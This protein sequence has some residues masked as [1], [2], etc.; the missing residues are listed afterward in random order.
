MVMAQN[1]LFNN[2]LKPCYMDKFQFLFQE[3]DSDL[4][5]ACLASSIEAGYDNNTIRVPVQNG[6]GSIL[7]ITLEEGL[8][9]GVWS[10]QLSKPFVFDKRSDNVSVDRIFHVAY[11][12]NPEAL[13]LKTKE[14]EKEFRV[15]GGLNTLFVSNDIDIEVE[16]AM[17]KGLQAI[18]ISFTSSW[19][20]KAF[21]DAD[22][23][24]LSFI[25]QLLKSPTPT[26]FFELTSGAE[27]RRLVEIHSSALAEAKDSLSIKAGAL[28]LLSGFFSKIFSKSFKEVLESKFLYYDKMLEVEQLLIAH[29]QKKLP[30]IDAIARQVA[31]SGSTLKRH[32]KMMF[33]KSVYEYYL[34]LKM[35]HAKHMLLESP[36]SVNEVAALLEYEKV[37]HF[38]VMFK[39]YHG[40]SP[41]SLRRKSA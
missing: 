9:L 3:V 16:V 24:F 8:Y 21:A 20:L 5:F 18:D 14:I 22:E 36:A 6:S 13:L 26:V 34:G 40:V 7:K 28:S 32:F 33:D 12:L 10:F 11:I 25:Q 27:Y 4:S 37:S 38:I 30:A 31:M 23:Q 2:H 17:D 15:Q 1:L 35:D 41:G 19:L 29:L 39:R